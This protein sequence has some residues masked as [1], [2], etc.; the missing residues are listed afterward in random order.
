MGGFAA[1]Y[2]QF[3]KTPPAHIDAVMGYY[4]GGEVPT[5]DF[6]AR[7][8]CV[9]DHWFAGLPLGTQANRLM[10]MAGESRLIDNS[11]LFLPDERLAYDWLTD[12][13]IPWCAYQ[14][15]DFL[16]FFSLMVKWLP[17]IGTSLTLSALGGRGR[18]R[19]FSRFRSEWASKKKMPNVIFVE[20]EYGDG[21][22]SHPNDDHPPTGVGP[23]QNLLADLYRVLTSNPAR[24]AKTLLV[25]TYD[26]HGGFFDHV[27]P[28]PIETII[29]GV[30][31]GTTGV[32]VPA[33][34]ISPHVAAG[35]VFSG[36]LDHTSLLQLLDDRFAGGKGYSPAVTHRQSAL[37][38]ISHA[39]LDKPRTDIPLLPAA[40]K[41]A[42]G[43]G[44]APTAE[45]AP[46]AP[47][48][49]PTPN[50]EA[51]DEALRKLARDHPELL[52]QPGWEQARAYLTTRPPPLAQAPDAVP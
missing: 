43:P 34:L 46:A 36:P 52:A 41:P 19:R 15:G 45:A 22:H 31:L 2:S 29:A 35:E 37:G 47:S 30:K 10:A 51:L 16:P 42:A 32:R 48:A 39:L 50:A 20:P 14:S 11:G 17:E 24:W 26:E 4:D 7:H 8:F 40:P 33:F 49:P 1:S 21:P 3:S 38:R 5:F 9:C 6:F 13:K 27:P 23:G 18:F 12:H 44:F 28:L 25:V